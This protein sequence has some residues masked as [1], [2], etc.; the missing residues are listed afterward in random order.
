MNNTLINLKKME[1]HTSQ[2]KAQSRYT[3]T[4]IT[5]THINRDQRGGGGGIT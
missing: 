3:W 4:D 2:T 1:K 5:E